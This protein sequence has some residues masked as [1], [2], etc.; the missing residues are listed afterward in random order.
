MSKKVVF[1]HFENINSLINTI[2][3]RPNNDVMNGRDSSRSGDSYFTGTNSY[4]EAEK[5]LEKGYTDILPQVKD[6]IRKMEKKVETEFQNIRKIYPENQVCGFVPHIPNSILNL[7][8]SMINVNLIP[9]KQKTINIIYTMGANCGQDKQ[10]FFDA[11]VTL[12]TAIKILELNRI[13]VK[14]TLGFMAAA[15]DKECTYPTVD[16]KGYGQRLDLQKLCFPLA[17]PSM[18]RRIGFK[19]LETVPN[20]TDHD[21]AWGYGR[22]PEE[23]DTEWEDFIKTIGIKK[24]NVILLRAQDIERMNFD[25]KKLLS[26]LKLKDTH[27]QS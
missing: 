7:P 3:S 22:S 1:E 9:Q 6:G 2:D 19:W 26:S 27:A 13:S 17:H 5:L 23:N 21:F 18:F 24:D 25:V 8:N 10:L 11:G 16:I 14:L 20:L 12:L 15:V 4:S